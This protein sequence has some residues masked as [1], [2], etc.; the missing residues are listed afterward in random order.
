M[1]AGA[2]FALRLSEKAKT[3][4]KYPFPIRKDRLPVQQDRYT[5]QAKGRECQKRRGHNEKNRDVSA[6]D[7][8]C[9]EC[10]ACN[11]H[12]RRKDVSAAG[13]VYVHRSCA[14][15]ALPPKSRLEIL[16]KS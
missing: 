5:G 14:G 1:E 12:G 10:A 11:M 15:Y 3:A 7:G 13:D 16:K 8:G 9:T 4:E 6:G 2:V